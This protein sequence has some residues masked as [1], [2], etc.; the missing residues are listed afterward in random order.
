MGVF[1]ISVG[2]FA[3]TG[4]ADGLS[5][6]LD[7]FGLEDHAQGLKERWSEVCAG[8]CAELSAGLCSGRPGG[9]CLTG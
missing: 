6:G 8:L 3:L 5:T 7:Q 1:A 9:L 2:D 4:L